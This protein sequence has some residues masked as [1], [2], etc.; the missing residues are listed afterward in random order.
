M[1][2]ASFAA[3]LVLLAFLLCPSAQAQSANL[4]P[5]GGTLVV[6]VPVAEGLVTC[7]DKRLYND[8]TGTYRD[9]F[10]KIH[11]VGRNA[12]FVATHTTGFLNKATGKMDFDVFEITSRYVSQ[13]NFTADRQFWDGV[14][15][16]IHDRL[17][18]DLSKI[19]Y[20]DWPATDTA[21]NKL[22]FNLIFYAVDSS[23]VRSYSMSVFYEKAPT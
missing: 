15:K 11:K 17:L 12:L 7:S 18:Q 14:K 16:E 9:D 2:L 1:K 20:A 5:L 21:N 3:N 13:H 23:K 4:Q 8:T 22:L 6:A 10:V 19:K